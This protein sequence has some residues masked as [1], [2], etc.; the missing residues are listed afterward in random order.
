MLPQQAIQPDVDMTH[1][2]IN[3]L[4]ITPVAATATAM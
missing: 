4:L 1:G 3:M 2:V